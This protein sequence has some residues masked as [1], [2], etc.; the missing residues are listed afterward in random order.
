M[1]TTSHL[2][3]T[4]RPILHVHIVDDPTDIEEVVACPPGA[5]PLSPGTGM[6]T[7]PAGEA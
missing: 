6:P 7:A 3:R 5:T 1:T 4:A 2:P